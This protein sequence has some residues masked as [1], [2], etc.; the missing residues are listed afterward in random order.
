MKD[1]ANTI[2]DKYAFE[3]TE[4]QI[5]IRAAIEMIANNVSRVELGN[6]KIQDPIYYL[7]TFFPIFLLRKFSLFLPFL[8]IFFYFLFFIFYFLF[9]IFYF[10]FFIFYFLFFI[11]YFL[12]FIFYFLLPQLRSSYGP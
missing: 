12:F 3:T 5:K 1:S 8:F 7:S 11:F 4:M 10:L 2:H 9:F 6:S